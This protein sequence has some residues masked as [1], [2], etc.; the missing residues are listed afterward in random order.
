MTS[1]LWRLFCFCIRICPRCEQSL[2]D[3]MTRLHWA[4]CQTAGCEARARYDGPER[5]RRP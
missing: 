2:Y 3:P 4:Y 1:L 5:R